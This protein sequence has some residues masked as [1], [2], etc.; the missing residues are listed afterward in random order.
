MKWEIGLE[1]DVKGDGGKST[2][3]SSK[4]L[5]LALM[6]DCVDVTENDR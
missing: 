1:N 6:R 5:R 2:S 3:S 4:D